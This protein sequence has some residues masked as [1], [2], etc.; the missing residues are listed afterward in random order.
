VALDAVL[1][2]FSVIQ[3]VLSLGA[4]VIAFGLRKTFE[5]GIF[6]KAWR[7]IAIA[8][9]IYGAGQAIAVIE[10]IFQETATLEPLGSVVQVVF[11][12]TLVIGLFMFASAW[13]SKPHDGGEEGYAKK[14]KGALVFFMGHTGASAVLVYTGEP[15]AED[16]ESKLRGVLGKG[17]SALIQR[18]AE[19][20]ATQG[21]IGERE[22]TA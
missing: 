6:E 10:A 21:E 8:P 16:F 3:L 11:L 12:V 14:A 9:I 5:G 20:R 15:R 19:E 18:T 4:A 7:V 2:T 17:A 13:S 22:K 1:A